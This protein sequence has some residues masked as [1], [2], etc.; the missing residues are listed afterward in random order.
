[1]S[2]QTIVPVYDLAYL[3]TMIL[4]RTRYRVSLNGRTLG[5]VEVV[6]VGGERHWLAEG[7]LIRFR[8]QAEA[9]A[10]LVELKRSPR[11]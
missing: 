6:A 3:S 1:M 5:N 11:A 8:T 9:I 2:Q 4:E 10:W 7:S